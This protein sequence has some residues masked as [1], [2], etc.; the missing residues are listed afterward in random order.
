M[1][2]TET[3]GVAEAANPRRNFLMGAGL[4][5]AGVAAGAVAGGVAGAVTAGSDDTESL[6]L[7]VACL[8]QTLRNIEFPRLDGVVPETGADGLDP[9]DLRGSP[10]YVEGWIY[11]AGT[12]AEGDGFI[13]TEDD[14]IGM[15]LCRGHL[16]ISPGREDP[17]VATLQEYYLGDVAENPIGTE[18]LA[19]Q[20]VEGRNLERWSA[21]RIVTGGTGVYRGARGQVTQSQIGFN[22]T[23]D[24]LGFTAPNFRFEFDIDLP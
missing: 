9:G 17:H 4:V 3:E 16:L 5:G 13:P 14:V 1:T 7:E 15:W 19:S 10:F 18:L 6:S 8:G 2:T 21:T 24:Y 23:V 11:P 20:G 12:I 22:S